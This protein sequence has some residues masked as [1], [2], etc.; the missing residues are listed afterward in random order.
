[1]RVKHHIFHVIRDLKIFLTI[2]LQRVALGLLQTSHCIFLLEG[3]TRLNILQ[4]VLQNTYV[5]SQ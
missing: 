5:I 4:Q 3:S 2:I 1:M